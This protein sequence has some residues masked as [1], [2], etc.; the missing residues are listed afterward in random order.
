MG[1]FANPAP[2]SCCYNAGQVLRPTTPAP[3]SHISLCHWDGCCHRGH[4]IGERNAE[5]A[6]FHRKPLLQTRAGVCVDGRATG[7]AGAIL[8]LGLRGERA[9]RKPGTTASIC[10]HGQQTWPS[11][12]RHR[13]PPLRG[14]TQGP[15]GPS[16]HASN[17]PGRR[18][19]NYFNEVLIT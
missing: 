10:P 2:D 5:S 17:V 1:H 19:F 18:A 8:G 16:T 12:H 15:T 7:V 13:P 9:P 4:G 14:D 6:A 3:D 11:P